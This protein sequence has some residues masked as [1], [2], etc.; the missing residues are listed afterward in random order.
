MKRKLLYEFAGSR[1]S[2]ENEQAT[3]MRPVNVDR[4]AVDAAFAALET[5]ETV[6]NGY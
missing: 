1:E 5:T 2:N 4:K 3:K 6:V